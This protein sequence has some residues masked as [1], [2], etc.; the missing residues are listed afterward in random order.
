MLRLSMH[1]RLSRHARAK[2]QEC[3]RR[4]LV[5]SLVA[6]SDGGAGRVE[7]P[8]LCA[9]CAGIVGGQEPQ[10]ILPAPPSELV[11]AA[12]REAMTTGAIVTRTYEA[13]GAI[14]QLQVQ[15]HRSPESKL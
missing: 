12:F 10:T 14:M 2:C 3:A 5:Y 4:R 1:T 15:T 7:S 8:R 13:D 11:D 9:E 6:E